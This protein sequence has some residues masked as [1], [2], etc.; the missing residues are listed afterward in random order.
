[1]QRTT[2]N[3]AIIHITNS[4]LVT[5]KLSEGMSA[6]KWQFLIKVIFGAVG[7]LLILALPA[8]ACGGYYSMSNYEF[9]AQM[10]FL[11]AIASILPYGIPLVAIIFVEAYILSKRESISYKKACGFTTLANIFYLI[12]CF[13]GAVFSIFWL[14]LLSGSVISA[15]ICLSFCQRTGYFKNISQRMFTFLIYLFFTGLGFAHLFLVESINV[16][17]DRTFLYIVTG[18]ILLIGFIF[19]FVMKGFAISRLMREKRL[20]LASSVMSMH[21]GSFPIIAIAYYLIQPLR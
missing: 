19:G 7:L 8:I 5:R 14:F 4:R 11:P 9:A 2:V 16:S 21:V 1:M 10:L 20:S 18:G 3:S 6:K 15:A 13:C 17:T 12:A